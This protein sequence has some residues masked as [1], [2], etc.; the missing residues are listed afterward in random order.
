MLRWAVS[1]FIAA[2][3]SCGSFSSAPWGRA[4]ALTAPFWSF[5]GRLIES[6]SLMAFSAGDGA[7]FAAAGFCVS[8]KWQ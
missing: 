1:F 2:S 8:V 5:G 3:I 6:C 4:A 7:L